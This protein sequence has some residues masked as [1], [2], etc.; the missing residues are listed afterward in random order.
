MNK[1]DEWFQLIGVK[2]IQ[3][4]LS[5]LDFPSSELQKTA[6][7]LI[8]FKQDER[9]LDKILNKLPTLEPE[10]KDQAVKIVHDYH[11]SSQ[12]RLKIFRQIMRWTEKGFD[13]IVLKVLTEFKK[14]PI[15]FNQHEV[16]ILLKLTKLIY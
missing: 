4:H 15:N 1:F 6:L 2:N 7:E 9:V 5:L 10:V 3:D 12:S 13:E 8:S 14:Q 16:D 11:I